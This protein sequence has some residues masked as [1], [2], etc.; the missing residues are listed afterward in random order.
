MYPPITVSKTN[1]FFIALCKESNSP[2][3]FFTLGVEIGDEKVLLGSFG[4]ISAENS[5]FCGLL[6]W[7]TN[8]KIKNERI[9][10]KPPALTAYNFIKIN[11]ED[12]IDSVQ[13]NTIYW[14]FIDNLIKYTLINPSGKKVSDT[15]R[16]GEVPN[17][18]D[19]ILR[20][21]FRRGHVEKRD[22]Q[23]EMTY[24][25]YTITYA[26][27]LKFMDYLRN[28]SKNQDSKTYPRLEAYYPSIYRGNQVTLEWMLLSAQGEIPDKNS[29]DHEHER[30]SKSNNCRHSAIKMTK[31]ATGLNDLGRGIS[32]LFT[33]DAPLKAK[34]VGGK[35]GAGDSYIYI[36]PLPP[37]CY[38]HISQ[39]KRDI[40]TKLY[41]RLDGLIVKKQESKVTIAKFKEIKNLYNSITANEEAS[42]EDI[43]A[44]INEWVTN[45]KE[46]I[47]THRESHWISFQTATE[48]MFNQL[49]KSQPKEISISLSGS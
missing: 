35:M 20:I 15:I 4:K 1:N 45:N 27:Y 48:K 11:S 3:S 22:V 5:S 28:I 13:K 19:I 34:S 33:R 10:I 29:I 39:K 18:E 43:F 40:I 46:L 16:L 37:N 42:L 32:S 30:I 36:L 6:F 41:N 26:Q 21:A 44:E 7:D 38:Q 9:F 25:A 49:L 31:R 14:G 24:K 47:R 8:A 2:H 23:A 17:I 12:D